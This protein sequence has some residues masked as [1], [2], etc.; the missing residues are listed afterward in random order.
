MRI[1]ERERCRGTA[2][3]MNVREG[4]E[5]RDRVCRLY[6]H[7]HEVTRSSHTHTQLEDFLGGSSKYGGWDLSKILRSA[8][9]NFKWNMFSH[10]MGA[11]LF[12]EHQAVSGWNKIMV[13]VYKRES[14]YV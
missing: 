9:P 6:A 4:E 1:V 14:W 2:E 13:E 8:S 5:E 12:E 3:G 10:T 11:Y 7:T